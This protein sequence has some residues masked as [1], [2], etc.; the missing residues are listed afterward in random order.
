MNH[1]TASDPPLAVPTASDP[2]NKIKK[3]GSYV[4]ASTCAFGNHV[5]NG[6]Q[7]NLIKKLNKNTQYNILLKTPTYNILYVLRT[8]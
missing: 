1:P 8:F 2:P 3:G 4:D 5:Y 7:G 6:T